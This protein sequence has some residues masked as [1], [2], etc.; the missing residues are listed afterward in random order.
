MIQVDDTTG[1]ALARTA[2]SLKYR[3]GGLRMGKGAKP[4]EFGLGKTELDAR[5]LFSVGPLGEH[6]PRTRTPRI[7]LLTVK[8]K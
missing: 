1:P 6:R 7:L 4:V 2:E 5:T 3:C 8:I